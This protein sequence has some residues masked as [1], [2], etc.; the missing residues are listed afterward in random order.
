MAKEKT[1][2]RKK[3]SKRKERKVKRKQDGGLFINPHSNTARVRE[4]AHARKRR[5]PCTC[6]YAEAGEASAE[7]V[8]NCFPHCAKDFALWA[9]YCRHF[10]RRRIVDKA[11]YYAS[12]SRQGEV[13]DGVSAFQA[14][15]R[16]EY[17]AKPE[18]GSGTASREL[19]EFI[20]SG[21]AADATDL[22]TVVSEAVKAGGAR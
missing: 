3:R 8:A 17:G 1:K 15:L 6:S 19:S 16:K 11:Y 12:C 7:I 22:S 4:G 10:D 2:E 13:R 14:W 21:S 9:W 5:L 18:A 20:N